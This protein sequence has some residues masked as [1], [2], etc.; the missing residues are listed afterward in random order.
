MSTPVFKAQASRLAQHLAD[1]HGI[2]LKHA[3]VLEAIAALHGARD[4]NTLS[5]S[6]AAGEGLQYVGAP[7][8]PLGPVQLDP[9]SSA[10]LDEHMA[11]LLAGVRHCQP[12]CSVC[13]QPFKDADDVRTRESDAGLRERLCRSCFLGEIAGQAAGHRPAHAHARVPHTL[14]VGAQDMGAAVLLEQMAVQHVSDGGGLLYIS[15]HQDVVLHEALHHAAG[16]APHKP[17]FLSLAPP[18]PA[19]VETCVP[20][21]EALVQAGYVMHLVPVPG[22]RAAASR[23]GVCLLLRQLDAV[24]AGRTT[25]SRTAS[26]HPLMVVLPAAHFDLSWLSMLRQGCSTGVTFVLQADSPADLDRIGLVFLKAVTE[27]VGTQLVLMPAGERALARTVSHVLASAVAPPER[28]VQVRKL[29]MHMGPGE[30]LR[31][32][33]GVLEAIRYD[34]RSDEASIQW[35]R[36]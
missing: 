22:E 31:L 4:W 35:S 24:L 25:G 3:S 28:E 10:S 15:G 2:K 23:A 32:R 8:L 36:A 27:N 1:K 13:V 21:L 20:R 11:T 7:V 16:E 26:L 18:N 29:L 9:I 12:K 34:G 5:A 6:T 30:A 33:E 17:Q 14:V 19:G